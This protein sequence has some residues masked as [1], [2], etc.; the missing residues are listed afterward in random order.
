MNNVNL[1]ACLLCTV[2]C[3][4]NP[5]RCASQTKSRL[6][7]N[8]ENADTIVAMPVKQV[9]IDSFHLVSE[10]AMPFRVYK[11]ME[12]IYYSFDHPANYS[13]LGT[14]VEKIQISLDKDSTVVRLYFIVP[15]TDALL[16]A[17]LKKFGSESG[18]WTA[19]SPLALPDDPVPYYHHWEIGEHYL[20][21]NDLLTAEDITARNSS[22]PQNKKIVISFTKSLKDYYTD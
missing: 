20:S 17:A 10:E 3:F 11:R 16:S 19:I 4:L 2:I 8:L 13:F 5:A 22:V 7:L 18:H 21:F 6:P 12:Q 15:Y 1:F 9:N 14:R